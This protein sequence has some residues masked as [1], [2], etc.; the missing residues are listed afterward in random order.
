MTKRDSLVEVRFSQGFFAPGYGTFQAGHKGEVPLHLAEQLESQGF[1][2]RIES[3]DD[4]AEDDKA[5]AKSPKPAAK[6]KVVTGAES[7][8]VAPTPQPVSIAT[9]PAVVKNQANVAHKGD[10]T[11]VAKG[12]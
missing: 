9:P 5:K 7:A 11:T 10:D 8:P 2:K 3:K 12:T 4:K 6:D 1:A